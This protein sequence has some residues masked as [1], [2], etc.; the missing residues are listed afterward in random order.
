MS[1]SPTHARPRGDLE[2]LA[3]CLEQIATSKV[4]LA[5]QLIA[6]A[7][8]LYEETRRHTEMPL[9]IE[10]Q[11]WFLARALSGEHALDYHRLVNRARVSASEAAAAQ[12][13]D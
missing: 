3:D 4:E 2:R 6:D 1:S 13:R 9:G 12:L 11:L 8:A 10:P 7:A 5:A